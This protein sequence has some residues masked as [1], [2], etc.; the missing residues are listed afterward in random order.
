MKKKL[1]QSI[2]ILSLCLVFVLFVGVTFVEAQTPPSSNVPG[3]LNVGPSTQT[4]QGSFIISNGGFRSAGPALL[5]DIVIIGTD[6]SYIQNQSTSFNYQNQKS[7]GLFA[8][9]GDF[10]G[11]TDDSLKTQ[12]AMAASQTCQSVGGTCTTESGSACLNSVNATGCLTD[13][14]C[15]ILGQDP[16]VDGI[17][18]NYPSGNHCA[19]GTMFD[20]TGGTNGPWSWSC[21][22]LNGGNPIDC[23]ANAPVVVEQGVCGSSNGMTFPSAPSSGLCS[24]GVTGT[25]SGSGSNTGYWKWSCRDSDW[26]TNTQSIP[27]NCTA[28]RTPFTNGACGAKNG[29]TFSSLT[30]GSSNL[31]NPGTVASFAG[32]GPWT[33]GCNGSGTGTNTSATACYASKTVSAPTANI[34][35]VYGNSNMVG[36]MTVNQALTVTG[37]ITS[38]N[39][40]VCL[41]D[42]TNCP[43][44]TAPATSFWN[45]SGTAGDI[46]NNNTGAIMIGVTSHNLPGY[47][48][49]VGG[50]LAVSG[51]MWTNGNIQMNGTGVNNFVS[52]ND[53]D[54]QVKGKKV[55]L[56]NGLEVSNN[57]LL[58]GDLTVGA[59]SN[60][61]FMGLAPSS[62][63]KPLCVDST[64]N[65]KICNPTPVTVNIGDSYSGGTVFYVDSS[66]EHGLVYSPTSLGS[67]SWSCTFPSLPSSN[68]V[69]MGT[70]AGNTSSLAANSN[71]DTNNTPLKLAM[72][73]SLGGYSDW[74]LPSKDE[75]YQLVMSQGLTQRYW[76]STYSHNGS[77]VN[78]WSVGPGNILEQQNIGYSGAQVIAVRA[79]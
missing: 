41:Q 27:A 54:F 66:G 57:T 52:I 49:F 47:K 61:K 35:T 8:K 15:C 70:G 31:C 28:N 13:E 38:N 2:K 6:P 9:L 67:P 51:G 4:K 19:V 5:N 75:L 22:G 53:T 10:F 26:E 44:A 73:Y 11:F 30:S 42:G 76:S 74:F 40:A 1:V 14:I 29:G 25:V 79:F 71:C 78:I 55:T 7:K 46:V 39:K 34:L 69:G 59:N 21:T 77:T 16:P 64:G 23:S 58:T 50:G 32:N 45:A 72:D 56:F 3:P 68:G 12:K 17:C 62:G 33:W 48:V 18:G 63:E 60:I 37:N 24:V 65:I 20:F 43:A 36:N